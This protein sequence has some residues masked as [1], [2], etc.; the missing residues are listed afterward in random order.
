[1]VGG[2]HVRHENDFAANRP[3]A[4]APNTVFGPDAAI[5]FDPSLAGDFAAGLSLGGGAPRLPPDLGDEDRA[6]GSSGVSQVHGRAISCVLG[7]ADE[8][9]AVIFRLVCNSF[10]P[11]LAHTLYSGPGCISAPNTRCQSF[12]QPLSKRAQVVLEGELVNTAVTGPGA[13]LALALMFLRT[14]DAAVAASFTLPTTAHTLDMV[15]LV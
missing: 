6:N 3:T 2:L 7:R 9:S 11:T 8:H 15:R 4:H 13:T 14:N 12:T 1:M 10:P 5:G